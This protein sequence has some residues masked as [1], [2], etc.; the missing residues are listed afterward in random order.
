VTRL[1]LVRREIREHLVPSA[2]ELLTSTADI[3]VEGGLS[4]ERASPTHALASVMVTLDLTRCPALFDE[5]VDETLA[6]RVAVLLSRDE[7]T[8][9][10]LVEL[11]RPELERL[12]GHRLPQAKIDLEPRIRH[13]GTSVLLDADAVVSLDA[14]AGGRR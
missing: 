14:P 5:A 13:E 2:L 3:V 11:V 1:R 6:E 10:K 9:T 8:R 12:A 4:P 7:W